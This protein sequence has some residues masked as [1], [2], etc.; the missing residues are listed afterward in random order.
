MVGGMSIQRSYSIKLLG[1][2]IDENQDWQT[3]FKKLKSALNQ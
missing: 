3:H 2:N 1:V